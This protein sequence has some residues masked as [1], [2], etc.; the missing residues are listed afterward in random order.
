MTFPKMG[1]Y[2]TNVKIILGTRLRY[3]VD[4]ACGITQLDNIG[5][6][7]LAVPITFAVLSLA[8]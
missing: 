4:G 7:C 6:L 5:V 2:G 8:K 3:T 1:E